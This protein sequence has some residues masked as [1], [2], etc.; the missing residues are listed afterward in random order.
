MILANWG[1]YISV[2]LKKTDDLQATLKGIQPIFEE[3]NPAYPFEYKFADVE[4][5]RK[6]TTINLTRKLATIF[7][8]LAMVITG[9]GLFG[10]A[11]YMAEQRIKEIGIRK[12]LGATIANLMGLMSKDFAKLVLVS[13][14]IAAPLS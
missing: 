8:A 12:V 9:L 4:F 1:G 7:A 6:F 3:H 10:L 14:F 2:R 11:S 5:Q 13:F